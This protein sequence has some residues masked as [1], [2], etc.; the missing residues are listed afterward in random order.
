MGLKK[1]TKIASKLLKMHRQ[2]HENQGVNKKKLD[3]HMKAMR[4]LIRHRLSFNLAHK[5]ANMSYPL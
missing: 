3:A 1:I 2:F 5:F 4:T